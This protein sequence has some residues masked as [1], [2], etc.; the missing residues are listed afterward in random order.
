MGNTAFWTDAELLVYINESLRVWNVMA[1]QWH[2]TATIPTTI[3]SML[4]DTSADFINVT[5]VLDPTTYEALTETSMFTLD[6]MEPGWQLLHSPSPTTWFPLGLTKIGLYPKPDSLGSVIVYG[7]TYA[8]QLVNDTNYLDL[9]EWLIQPLLDYVEHIACFKQGGK[10]FEYSA[11]LYKNFI[12]AA[13]IQ[14]TKL[15]LSGMYRRLMGVDLEQG[16]RPQIAG[17]ENGNGSANT[18]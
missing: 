1:R 14:N 17:T 4:V 11:Q 3:G 13:G 8:P 10:E 15:Q 2:K 6:Q 9:G 7:L 5:R 16:Q 12:K 18:Q